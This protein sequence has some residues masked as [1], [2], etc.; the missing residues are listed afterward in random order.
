MKTYIIFYRI[1][2]PKTANTFDREM[3]VV[4]KNKE[5]AIECFYKKVSHEGKIT[6][7]GIYRAVNDE[8]RLC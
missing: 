2:D 8:G 6:I 7:L 1:L 5:E 4:A 3:E